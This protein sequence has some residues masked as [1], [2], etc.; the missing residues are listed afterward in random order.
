MWRIRGEISGSEMDDISMVNIGLT[1][2]RDVEADTS[3]N[4]LIG[5]PIIVDYA[6]VSD[7]SVTRV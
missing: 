1:S 5:G 2:G 7:L 4:D 6:A 3:N